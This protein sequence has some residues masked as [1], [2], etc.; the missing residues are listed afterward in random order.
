MV[1]LCPS[2]RNIW[3]IFIPLIDLVNLEHAFDSTNVGVSMRLPKH[4]NIYSLYTEFYIL[5]NWWGKII[6]KYF[7]FAVHGVVSY[8][9]E[10]Y[11]ER[12]HV[13]TV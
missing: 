3:I 9:F 2:H 8:N 1:L 11:N 13:N 10:D 5:V 12:V 4:F 7:A 6:S